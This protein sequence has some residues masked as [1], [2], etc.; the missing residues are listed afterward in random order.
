MMVEVDKLGRRTSTMVAVF[1][2]LLTK[3]ANTPDH[4]EVVRLGRDLIQEVSALISADE[5]NNGN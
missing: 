4:D 1:A 3:T 5:H 2:R